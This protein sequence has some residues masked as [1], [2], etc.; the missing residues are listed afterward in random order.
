MDELFEALLL[1]AA[2]FTA[3][4]KF[5][6]EEFLFKEQ[7]DLVRDPAKFATA[8][9]SVRAGKTIACAADLINTAITK[10][11]TVGL[12]ITLARSSAKRIVWPELHNIN[13]NYKLEAIPN[14]SDLSFK[15]PNGSIIYCSGASDGAEIE[16]FR[17]L[18]NVALAYLDESQAF[19]S[20]IKELVEEILIKR[21]YDTNGR[22]RLIGTPGPIPSGYFHDASKSNQWSHHA[23]TLH[24]N[25]WIQKKSGKTVAELIQQD[26]D[27]KGVTLDDPSIQ[28]ECFGRWVLDS[29]ALLLNYNPLLNHYEKLPE[30]L[31]G[32]W[33]YIL[34]MDFGFD[35]ADSFSVL[36]FSDH[37]PNTYLVEEVINAG[38]TY[39]QMAQTVDGLFKKY[40][41]CKVMADPGGGGKKLIESLKQRYPI[42]F[43]AADKQGKIA[44]YGLLNN[45]LRTGRFYAKKDSRFAQDCNL[46]E[47]DMDRSTPDKTIVKGHSD[48]VD[49]C[50][51]AFRESPAYGYTP[52]IPQP[53]V[54]T[55]EYEEKFAEEM[56]NHT[57]TKLERERQN[58]D[59]Q[60]MNWNVDNQGLADWQKWSD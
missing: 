3:K 40:D 4:P 2:A 46:L 23:W 56:F 27:R 9:C 58:K 60:G 13:R 29:Q 38:H 22:L 51:Y 42:P 35:D 10:P 53:K 50:L 49:S 14:E 32:N 1:E 21:L 19:R 52:P 47:K 31:K 55:K 57:M 11:G 48:A 36:A 17:G 26:C 44:N 39:D 45:A 7:L 24:N 15:F 12:Y 8:V 43:N 6:I 41:F 59:N 30:L 5:N 33:N 54:G 20:H 25:P 34:G 18:S 37:N 16:K 28:R